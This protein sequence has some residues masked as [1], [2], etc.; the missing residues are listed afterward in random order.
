MDDY[1]A[2]QYAY[3]AVLSLEDAVSKSVGKKLFTPTQV[4][5]AFSLKVEMQMLQ[6]V[7]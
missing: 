2:T 5:T 7:K 1:D 6:K 3:R 4:I